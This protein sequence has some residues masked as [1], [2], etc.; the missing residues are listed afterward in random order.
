MSG[1]IA[2]PSLATGGEMGARIRTFDWDRTP[3]GAPAQWSNSLRSIVS[4][5]LSTRHQMFLWWGPALV[6]F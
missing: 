6:Q 5:I 4:V 2:D 1:V 3:V